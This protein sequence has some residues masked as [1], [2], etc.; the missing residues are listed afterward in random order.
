LGRGIFP[1]PQLSFGRVKNPEKNPEK[2]PKNFREDYVR[3][4][5]VRDFYVR[6][7]FVAP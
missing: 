7:K 3:D 1:L 4:F 5:Y 2:I 6:E